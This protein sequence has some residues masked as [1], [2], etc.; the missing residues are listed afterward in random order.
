VARW[1]AD[2]SRLTGE[3]LGSGPEA[4]SIIEGRDKV[5]AEL[6]LQVVSEGRGGLELT[7]LAGV[8]VMALAYLWRRRAALREFSGAL[9]CVTGGQGAGRCYGWRTVGRALK[10]ATSALTSY[11]RP[12]PP[13][14]R[15]V[16]RPRPPPP[17][18]EIEKEAARMIGRVMTEAAEERRERLVTR[19]QLERAEPQAVARDRTYHAPSRESHVAGRALGAVLAVLIASG[20]V[21]PDAD[22]G[23]DFPG[24][25]FWESIH[26]RMPVRK[27]EAR[28]ARQRQPK[29]EAGSGDGGRSVWPKTW[30]LLEAPRR[31]APPPPGPA[32]PSVDRLGGGGRLTR[33]LAYPDR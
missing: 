21:S 6:V 1:A 25:P 9:V 7:V 2:S 11:L 29:A 8:F 5:R 12:P 17:P 24:G 4:Q 10:A 28:R 16:S 19:R 15:V 30:V 33:R 27:R 18:T 20:D 23:D 31:S 13:P 14:K 26:S 3:S 32:P 22:E